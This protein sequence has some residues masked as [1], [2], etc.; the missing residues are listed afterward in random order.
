MLYYR[1]F[2]SHDGDGEEEEEEQSDVI[3]VIGDL[4]KAYNV[5]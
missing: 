4:P 2:S 5:E 1:M 3:N